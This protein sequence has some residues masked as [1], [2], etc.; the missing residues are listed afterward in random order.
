[1]G[2]IF[3]AIVFAL[4]ALACF[5]I[6]FH[7]RFPLKYQKFVGAFFVL[8]SVYNV[9]KTSYINVPEG[10]I[11]TLERQYFAETLPPGKVMVYDPDKVYKGS[12]AEYLT[13]GFHFSLF[14]NI[15][16]DSTVVPM[17]NVEQG[18]YLI[19][20]AREG[21]TLP[22]GEFMAPEWTIPEDEMLKPS[23]FLKSKGYK[24][25]QLTVLR[26]GKY[27]IHPG[28]WDFKLGH[29]VTVNTGEVAV[30]HSNV[31]LS[32][33]LDCQPLHQNAS[34]SGDFSAVL[35]KKGC[36]GVWNE[37]LPSGSYYLNNLA[38]TPTIQSTRASTW[39]YKGGYT[40]REISFKVD[41]KGEIAQN[42][43]TT[44]VDIKDSYAD[45]AVL[46]RT[47]DGWT[48][49]IEV[50]VP[51]QV[52]PEHAPRVVAGIGSTEAI[53]DRVITPIINDI[54]RQIGGVTPA[55]ELLSKR[56]EIVD[57]IEKAVRVE[58]IKAGVTVQEVRLD[59]IV[60][61]P[62]LLLPERRKQLASSLKDTY[63]EEQKAAEQ[64]TSSEKAKA[65]ANNQGV[66]V[67]ADI[68]AQAAARRGEGMRDEMIAIA[69][70]QKAQREVVGAE[71]A[72]Q[73][74]ML[75]KFLN[76]AERVPEIVK[77]PLINVQSG[78][79]SSGEGM[80]AI[81]GGSSNL[82]SMMKLQQDAAAAAKK[83]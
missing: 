8:C 2:L 83:P 57:A 29:A 32:P 13:P 64:R 54:T 18:T 5:N 1:M 53:E 19:L 40:R 11:V 62:E 43:S 56:S 73:L 16:N 60:I 81:L 28:L 14:I 68:N 42:E 77:V 49:P 67:T 36:K 70:G 75:D 55:R 39:N 6:Q 50:R 47:S 35:V 65:I 7:P 26:P 63:I 4:I 78:N 21:E 25:T 24:G 71:F 48:I 20:V 9:F 82:A 37:P 76:V 34:P 74:Q 45:A 59:D 31:Q 27:P 80:A 58:A 41:D 38:F 79:Q 12:Q 15:L 66:L 72:V 3:F 69:A 17:T 23:V 10:H 30:I 46:V 61:P 44:P 22:A 51:Y 33:N 52:Y